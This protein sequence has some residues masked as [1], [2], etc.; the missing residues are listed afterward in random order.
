[1]FCDACAKQDTLM[2]VDLRLGRRRVK[3]KKIQEE[4]IVE[5]LIGA[6]K[7]HEERTVEILSDI[8]NG[9]YDGREE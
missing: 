8:S 3:Y 2:K 7:H 1:M 5:A 6:G 4:D 9:Q